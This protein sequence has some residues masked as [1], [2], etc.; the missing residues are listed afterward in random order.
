M[1]VKYIFLKNASKIF[2]IPTIRHAYLV[3]KQNRHILHFC[4]I[5]IKQLFTFMIWIVDKKKKLSLKFNS[6]DMNIS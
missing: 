3:E 2:K 6:V 1:Q 5:F 4:D